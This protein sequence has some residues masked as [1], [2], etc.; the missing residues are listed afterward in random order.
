MK[1]RK[2]PIHQ[3]SPVTQG[4]LKPIRWIA[5]LV[6]VLVFFLYVKTSSLTLISCGDSAEMTAAA[7]SFGVAHAPGYPLFTLGGGVFSLFTPHAPAWGV[8]LFN[9]LSGSLAIVALFF[10]LTLLTGQLLAAFAGALTLACSYHFWLY[11]HVPEITALNAF[12]YGLIVLSVLNLSPSFQTPEEAIRTNP[13]KLYGLA[14]FLGL[15]FSHHHSIVFMVPGVLIGVIAWAKKN[16]T[17]LGP[18]AWLAAVGCLFIGLTPYLYVPL[19]AHAMPYMNAGTVTTFSRFIDH[20]T[21]RA[22]G[23]TSLTPEYTPFNEPAMASVLAFYGQSLLKS[24]SWAG[25]VL[26]LWGFGVL[27]WKSPRIFLMIGLSGFLAGPFF[28]AWAGMPATSV[29]LKTILERF[30]VASFL[31]FAVGIGVG[32]AQLSEHVRK[33]AGGKRHPKT[34]AALVFVLLLVLPTFLLARNFRRLNF[35]TFDLCERYGRDLLFT[36]PPNAVLFVNGDNSLFTLWYLQR[37]SRV[38]TDI[39]ILNANISAAYA[40]HIRVHYPELGFGPQGTPT[41][42]K[43]ITNN[44]GKFPLFLIGVPGTEFQELGVLGNPF[45]LRP[46]GLAFEIAQDVNLEMEPEGLDSWAGVPPVPAALRENYFV[47]EIFYLYSIGHYNRAVIHATQGHFRA[48]YD[49]SQMALDVDPH[50]ELARTL[51][52][53]MAQKVGWR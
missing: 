14:F 37:L 47:E 40:D 45:V 25:I 6:G 9:A 36:L 7:A 8:H 4:P 32:M 2:P 24:F 28:L 51:R 41:L 15:A 3:H 39:K 22:Y 48:S 35:A 13:K 44:Y 34:A 31:L 38:R 19:R 10:I 27:L 17:P 1:Q 12:F 30:F 18:K 46:S 50:F 53:R 43:V 29:V 26:G 20:F 52:N 5:T 49:A 42:K 33:S 11:A 16:K 21:R 23:V